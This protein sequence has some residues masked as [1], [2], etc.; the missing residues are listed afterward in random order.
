MADF[1]RS[2]SMVKPGWQAVLSRTRVETERRVV[3][4]TKPAAPMELK[5]YRDNYTSTTKYSLL[6]FLP[7]ALFEQYRRARCAALRSAG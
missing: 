5:E 6:T 3:F 4:R 7:V 2:D 1:H